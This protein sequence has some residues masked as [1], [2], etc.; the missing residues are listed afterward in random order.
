MSLLREA[1]IVV[2][3]T[4]GHLRRSEGRRRGLLDRELRQGAALQP[5][6]GPGHAARPGLPPGA[7]PLFRLGAPPT[8]APA[9]GG[10]KREVAGGGN[11]RPRR[12]DRRIA[13]PAA[14]GRHAAPVLVSRH[15]SEPRRFRCLGHT[16]RR[17]R[18]AD[19]RLVR[20]VA[21][22]YAP[23]GRASGAQ[24]LP[25]RTNGSPFRTSGLP[26]MDERLARLDDRF[27]R[28]EAR[29]AAMEHGQAKL[30]GLLE[31]LR[32]AIAGRVRAA[33]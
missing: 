7:R 1:G 21:R 32:E 6:G 20:P 8:V 10:L 31:G 23:H 18:H 28:M 22:R 15:G 3:R 5:G 17:P 9:P 12:T 29:L 26:V 13:S 25:V 30:E 14:G 4:A 24:N 11:L 27:D 16:V 19:S 33:E 2:E